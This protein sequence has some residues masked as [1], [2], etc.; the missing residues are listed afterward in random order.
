MKFII[1]WINLI[2]LKNRDS[3]GVFGQQLFYE[4]ILV[5][6]KLLK[7]RKT[8]PFDLTNPF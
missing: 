6:Q 8:L 2:K 3:F 7:F 4:H 1:L 5:L